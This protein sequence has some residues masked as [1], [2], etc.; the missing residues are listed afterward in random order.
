MRRRAA[1]TGL[2]LAHAPVRA[3][4]AAEEAKGFTPAQIGVGAEIYARNCSPCHSPR[5]QYPESAAD[6]RKFPRDQYQRF[7]NV[8][9]RGRNQMPPW[10]DLFKPDELEA[11]WAYVVAGER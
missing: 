11:L 2:A 1:A 5:M 4:A 6:L 10:G 8:V 7:V 3:P 9:R